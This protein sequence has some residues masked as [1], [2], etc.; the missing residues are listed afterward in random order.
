MS[1]SRFD[2]IAAPELAILAV[3]DTT[4]EIT[5]MALVAAHL[6]LLD[7]NV[8]LENPCDPN[9]PESAAAS[10]A[11]AILALTESLRHQLAAYQDA[12][13]AD[14]ARARAQEIPF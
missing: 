6:D 1:H 11:R 13:D 9:P 8:Q 12:L 10:V 4:F 3:L 14:L 5:A 7:P 2:L